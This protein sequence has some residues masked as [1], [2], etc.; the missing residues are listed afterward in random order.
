[1]TVAAFLMLA[2]AVGW[3]VQRAWC[4]TPEDVHLVALARS[5]F[6]NLTKAELALLRFAGAK[7]APG[8]AFAAAGPS[9]NPADPSN[10]PA[11]ADEWSKDREVRA[12]LIWWLCVDPEAVRYIT[13]PGLRLL[14]AKIVGGLNLSM[15]RVPFAI[16]L[17]N[18]SIPE[19]I[20]LTSTTISTLDLSGSYTGPIHAGLINVAESLV[21][22]NGFHAAGQ[23]DL[24]RAKIGLLSATAGHFR[25]SPDPDDLFPNVKTALNLASSRI[26]F[27]VLMD[28]GF[29]SQGAVVLLHTVTEGGLACI[30]G[31]F[32]NPGN[33]AIFAQD[34]EIGG[35]V[36]LWGEEPWLAGATG[37]FEA[38]GLVSFEGARVK[39]EFIVDGARLIGTMPPSGAGG[40]DGV[41][42]EVR[43]GFFWRRVSLENGAQLRLKHASVGFIADR[44]GGWPPPGKLLID[45]FV[46]SFVQPRPGG[47]SPWDAHTRLRWLALQPPGFHP[48]PYRQLA[49]VLR[50]SGDEPGALQ[51]QIAEQDARYRE[52]GLL[53]RFAGAFLKGTIG[54]GYRP[55]RTVGWSLLFVLFGWSVVWAAKR[56]GVMR[57]TWPE[58]APAS[59]EPDYEDLHPFLYSL[60]VFLPFVNLHQ[61]HY[62][63]PDSKTSGQCALFGYQLRLRGSLVRYYLWVQVI[64]GWLLSAILVAG[65][66]GLMRSD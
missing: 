40:L 29:E 2:V 28:R 34:A 4:A 58:N 32:I 7:Q 44:E 9:S 26:K 39:G 38:D 8:G 21:L 52:S 56:A 64:S 42:L 66:T 5:K 59:S 46:Y 65:L 3:D 13:P 30:S 16:T 48:Q 6:A 1:M 41:D 12:A 54:Y 18:C 37:P 51:V 36:Y 17:R 24:S 55:L 62:W 22:G 49:K 35:N 14:G 63:W 60:D 47:D 61:E 27:G 11:H 10:D 43:G 31:R 33:N 20:E 53:G 19:M 57:A 45:G 15:V 50:E 23:V 25:Y